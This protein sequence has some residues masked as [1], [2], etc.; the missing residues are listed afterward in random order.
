MTGLICTAELSHSCLKWKSLIVASAKRRAIYA[1]YLISTVY[2]ALS[3]IP[4]FFVEELK[5]VP[6]P[7]GKVLW[8][9]RR[10]GDLGTG[11]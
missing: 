3:K 6:V 10:R 7:A 2:N 1:M 8:E 9:A 4:D 11:L 5:G